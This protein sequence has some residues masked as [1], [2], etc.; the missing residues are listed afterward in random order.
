MATFE[1]REIVDEIIAADGDPDG[2]PIVAVKVVE[3]ESVAGRTVWGVVYRPR[4]GLPIEDEFRYERETEFVRNPR[5][6]W[7][8]GQ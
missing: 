6:I 5:V 8:R 2:E 3:Y 4:R 1:H 7:R